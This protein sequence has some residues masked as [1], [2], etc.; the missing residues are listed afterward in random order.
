MESIKPGDFV[1]DKKTY[2]V[3]VVTNVS[4]TGI[5]LHTGETRPRKELS[6]ILEIPKLSEEEIKRRALLNRAYKAKLPIQHRIRE[7]INAPWRDLPSPNHIPH[8]LWEKYDHKLASEATEE[9]REKIT[10]SEIVFIRVDVAETPTICPI[11][12]ERLAEIR[13]RSSYKLYNKE[14]NSWE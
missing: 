13:E 9:K 14:T 6:D 7:D 1:C 11:F 3:F 2:K 5:E 8:L 4:E 12:K 10:N